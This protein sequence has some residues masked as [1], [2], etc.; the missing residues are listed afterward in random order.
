MIILSN[1]KC[2]LKET[3]TTQEMTEQKPS[4]GIVVDA[5]SP[6]HR[7][8]LWIPNADSDNSLG[9]INFD[10]YHI[11]LTLPMLGV[12]ISCFIPR[13]RIPSQPDQTN[14]ILC[15]ICQSIPVIS[16]NGFK[17]H[18]LPEIKKFYYL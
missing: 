12:K 11:Y 2:R 4:K 8:K 18:P 14:Y 7:F 6:N 5:G 1:I 13:L 15:P 16:R 17:S 3:L 10:I 9:T